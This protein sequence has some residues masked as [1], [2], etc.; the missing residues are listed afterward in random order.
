[1]IRNKYSVFSIIL[2]IL[3][4]ISVVYFYAG[5]NK[6][7]GYG[8]EL[9]TSASKPIK[10]KLDIFLSN[11][12]KSVKYF[13]NEIS[14]TGK[15]DIIPAKIDTL[16][17]NL[18]KN[19]NEIKG[20]V[21]FSDT[22]RYV[23]LNGNGSFVTTFATKSDTLLN[24]KRVDEN[25]KK[26]SEW[27][28]TYNFFL[29][30][31]NAKILENTPLKQG[32]V[33]WVK[34]TSEI[35]GRKDIILEV[36]H[37]KTSGN[38]N[39]YVAYIFQTDELS[40]FFLNKFYLKNPVI[41][42]FTDNGEVFTPI[43]T[44]DTNTIKVIKKVENRV[45]EIFKTWKNN[46]NG[47][48]HSYSFELDNKIFWTRVDTVKNSTGL[49]A[50]ALTVSKNNLTGFYSKIKNVY[51]YLGI[52]LIITG[53]VIILI[54]TTKKRLKRFSKIKL[55]EKL[56]KSEILN[57]IKQGES[58]KVEFKS[59][60]RYD[61][62]QEKENKLLEDVILKS[63][64]SFSNAKGGTLFIGVKD[65]GEI[66]GLENDFNTLKKKDVDYFELHLR[67]LIKNQFGINFSN[68]NLIIHFPE[69]DG[70]I[71]AVVQVAPASK[72]VYLKVKNKQGQWVEKFFVRSG[73]SSQEITSLKELEEYIKNRFGKQIIIN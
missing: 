66:L 27:T 14:K 52:L 4:V 10:Q 13:N 67:S 46:Y 58:D 57:L 51:L 49:K 3:G 34:L 62:R 26:V 2:I 50:F 38:Y 22:L 21:L 59:S 16:A 68:H 30:K 24:W 73:N 72:P 54:L 42:F 8:E 41:S 31:R 47:S 15:K 20:I 40:K 6:D 7:E 9:I 70:K 64:A 19:N 25:L 48:P 29:N 35:P 1:M 56:N 28:D 23:F 5:A 18:L 61:Y 36:N 69:I 12:N 63:I 39:I 37:L 17:L 53:L 55:P 44:D 32:E 33:K 11:V 43:A 45:K 71:I 60:L 65:D